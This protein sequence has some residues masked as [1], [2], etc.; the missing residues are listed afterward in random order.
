MLAIVL[1]HLARQRN[2][3]LQLFHVHHGLLAQ[4]DGWTKQV[5]DLAKLLGRPLDIL[6]IDIAS[7]E[8]KGMEAAARDARYHA[9]A[10]AAA[11]QGVNTLWLAHHQDDQAE[12]V[13][14]RLLRGAGVAGMGAMRSE[15]TRDG[16]RYLR[17]WLSVPRSVILQA[18]SEF[19]H[20]TGWAPVLDPSNV[21]PRY[22]R[23]AVRTALTPALN[24]RWPGWQAIVARHARQ[25][26]EAAA[27]LEEVAAADLATIR[28]G[29]DKSAPALE[30]DVAF[31]LLGWRA[32]SA[33]RQRNLLRYWLSL[34]GARMPSEARLADLQRQLMQL[35]SLGHDRNMVFDHGTLRIRCVRGQVRAENRPKKSDLQQEGC[36]GLE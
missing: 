10:Q 32:L 29:P 19:T 22:T 8:G 21:D 9:L 6:R 4:A 27:L 16:V 31:E 26:D 15:T 1:D 17:P 2:V 25:A 11:R 23:A 35:H 20:A 12:T 3:S 5:G 13:L 24:A 18:M 14:L 33:P 36:K 7:F 30:F 34:L 28:S